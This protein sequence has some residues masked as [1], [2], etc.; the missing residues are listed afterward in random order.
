MTPLLRAAALLTLTLLLA[1]AG[2][3]AATLH[4]LR[5]RPGEWSV[6]LALGPWRIDARVPTL[7]RWGTHP[8]AAAL[9]DGRRFHGASGHWRLER[10]PADGLRLR[11]AP[12]R[13][14]L[15]ALGPQPLELPQAQLEWQALGGNQY[16]GRLRLG[17][18][19]NA[20]AV[21]QWRATLQREAV[22]WHA[23]LPT[24]P[25]AAV[26]G[27]FGAA[28]PEAQRA[29]IEGEVTLTLAG[30][31]DRGGLRIDQL[32]TE[33]TALAVFGLGTEALVDA[34]PATRCRPQPVGG[35]VQGWLPPAVLAAEDQR[36]AQHA[37]FE[38]AQWLA[39]LQGNAAANGA[40]HGAS[41]LTQQ[42]AK[43]LYTG[44]ERSLA[45]KLRE[46]LYAVEMERTL[47][48]GRI[49]QLYLAVAPWGD[50]L[51]G[52][53]AAAH[54]YFGKPARRLAP[55]EA[56]WLANLLVNPELQWRRW[57]QGDRATRERA[58]WI[59]HGMHLLP[60]AQRAPV[61]AA[62]ADLAPPV[63]VVAENAAQVASADNA[64]HA[65]RLRRGSPPQRLASTRP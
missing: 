51:C 65:V 20:A 22:L 41:T 37:G 52:A 14:R 24:T 31:I 25:V 54:R 50:D 30:R 38:S 56:A 49:A 4:V 3:T 19:D 46:W 1:V 42:L 40:L 12:C 26:V 2:L 7:L 58:A 11:C 28:I 13:L 35:R 53:E 45:R 16:A 9:L 47:G 44:D 48:K 64:D 5:A 32:H 61:L 39:A 43:L 36:F 34:D 59:V 62:L 33:F 63:P 10:A 8:L 6:P 17:S 27:A 57:A 29:R 18:G 55:H 23:E 21:V 60:A 15:A